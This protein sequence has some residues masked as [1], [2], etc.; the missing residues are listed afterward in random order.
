MRETESAVTIHVCKILENGT[1]KAIPRA[2]GELRIYVV[3]SAPQPQGPP[4]GAGP[5]ERW[6]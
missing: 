2:L 4:L 1:T 5:S 3:A 6:R